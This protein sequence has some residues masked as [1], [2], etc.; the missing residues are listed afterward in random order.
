[1][2]KREE[3]PTSRLFSGLG[4]ASMRSDWTPNATFALFL[5]SPLWLGGHQHADNNSFIIDKNGLL[6]IDSGV[7]EG[8]AH[9]ANYYARTIAHNTVTCSDPNEK[10]NGGVWGAGNPGK[11]NNDGGQLFDSGSER[12]NDIKPDDEYHRGKILAYNGNNVY[13]YVVGDATLSYSPDKLREF[14]R[15]FLY[16]KPNI[17]VIFD[18]VESTKAEFVKTWLLHSAYEPMINNSM[19]NIS[20]GKGQ[21]HVWTVFPFDPEIEKI[22]GQG[23][24]FEVNGVNYPPTEKTDYNADEAGRWRIEVRSKEQSERQYFFHVLVTDDAEITSITSKI[25]IESLDQDGKL[26]VIIKNSD[27]TIKVLFTKEDSL[28]GT[29]ELINGNTIQL[30]QI[31]TK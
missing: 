31:I 18:R 4:W 12:V 20:N 24:E 2:I 19:A 22:G 11:G 29:M 23:H 26:G 13:T 15:A 17:F 7:Y 9:R 3:L 28:T 21:L 8:T 6:A 5:C 25:S 16:I 14:T 27:R 1:M 30:E 10:F